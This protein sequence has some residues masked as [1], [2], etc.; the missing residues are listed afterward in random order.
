MTDDNDSEIEKCCYWCEHYEI[1][2]LMS[3]RGICKIGKYKR[4]KHARHWMHPCTPAC[5]DYVESED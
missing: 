2:D 4:K 5:E 3:E 1:K